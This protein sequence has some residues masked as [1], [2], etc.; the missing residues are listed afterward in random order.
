MYK[1]LFIK[2]LVLAGLF[3]IC[4][5]GESQNVSMRISFLQND[6]AI[7]QTTN[8]LMLNGC[9]DRVVHS[10]CRVLNWYNASDTDLN[11]KR[12]SSSQ[13]G[14]FPFQTIEA[15][16]EKLDCP[17]IYAHHQPELNCFD[18]V[19]LLAGDAT[20][21]K[22]SPDETSGP[23]FPAAVTTNADVVLRVV[24]TPRDAFEK[25]C[26]RWW[27][28]ASKTIYEG[29]LQDKRICLFAAFDSFYFLPSATTRENLRDRLFKV[30]QL[31]WQHDGI[32]FPTNMDIVLFHSVDLDNC[33]SLVTHAGVLFPRKGG[34]V[35]IEKLG[36]TGPYVR[37]DIAEKKDLFSWYKTA[38][39][40]TTDVGNP[41]FV[42]FNDTEIYDLDQ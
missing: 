40:P 6:E 11:T 18:V 26:P 39:K 33:N 17:L 38:V 16:T 8:F 7:N 24:A 12:L 3:T 25:A 5:T 10:F 34:Y 14:F 27:I 20:T 4:V 36:S 9:S 35:Y 19:S 15:L 29:S 1:L 42:T 41:L 32:T 23:F 30:L 28:D 13:N 2:L 22:L 37:L 21:T 31:S